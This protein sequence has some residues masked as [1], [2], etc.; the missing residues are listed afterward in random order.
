MVVGLHNIRLLLTDPFGKVFERGTIIFVGPDSWL[1]RR[2]SPHL[3][4]AL[5]SFAV[6]AK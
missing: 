5:A 2:Q 4:A 6:P 3:R 1:R